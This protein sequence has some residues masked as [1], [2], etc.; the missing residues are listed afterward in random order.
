MK[1]LKQSLTFVSLFAG[2][3]GLDLGFVRAGLRPVWSNEIDPDAVATYDAVMKQLGVDHRATCGDL[4]KQAIPRR[5]SADLVIGGPP[6]QGFSVAGHMNPSDPRSQHVMN[7]FDVVERVQPRGFVMENVMGLALNHRW[8]GLREALF[9]RAEGLGFQTKLWLLRAS[10]YGVPQKRERMFLVGLR[11]ATPVQPEVSREPVRTVRSALL[12]LPKYGDPGNDTLCP[13]KVTLAR[14][15]VLRRS[16]YAGMLF[17][18]QGRPLNLDCPSPTLPASMGGN[19]TP[20]I[21]QLEL[22]TG[23]EAWVR[24]YHGRLW[25]GKPP[26]VRAPKHL[27]RL[28]VEEATVLQT[29]PPDTP[30]QGTLASKF[31]QIGNAV[32]PVLAEQVAAT[33]LRQLDVESATSL[34]AA[35]A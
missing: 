11:D 21:D 1:G 8:T 27:R 18:G 29:F 13:A 26:L 6:C 10:D 19:R 3:G 23:V 28:T 33:I 34:T 30:W 20:I 32:P 2:A 12:A 31:R 35:A 7:F 16:P 17:N 25:A 9:H 24:R 15:P 4:L 5:G 14:R 22:E